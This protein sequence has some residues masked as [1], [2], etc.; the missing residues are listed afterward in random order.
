MSDP[1]TPN[2]PSSESPV[3]ESEPAATPVVEAPTPAPSAPEAAVPES[4]PLPP[5]PEAASVPD[6]AV[7]D[8]AVPE[9]AVPD[10]AVPDHAVVETAVVETAVVETAVLE[11]AV[12]EA[13]SVEVMASER[14]AEPAAERAA[15]AEPAAEA[16]AQPEASGAPA[17]P[18]MPATDDG[19]ALAYQPGDIVP[20]TVS[21]VRDDGVDIDLDA[22][23]RAIAPK[24]EWVGGATYAVGD[25][26]EGQVLRRQGA[27]KYVVS[28]K[29]A[30]KTR[31]WTRILAAK[32]SGEVMTGTVTEVVK[33]GLIVDLGLRAFL[34]E[35]LID[36]RRVGKPGELVGQSV[37][38][39]V[40]E[41]EKATDRPGERIVVSRKPLREKE[42]AEA[43]SQL[44][45]TIQPGERRRGRVSAIVPF[46]AFVDL[47]GIDGLIHVSEIAHSQV[48]SADKVLSVGEEVDVVVLEVNPEKR[49]IA[50]SRKR[51]LPDPW[52]AFQGQHQVGDLVFGTISGLAAFGAFVAIEGAELEGLIHISELSR[53]R[54]EQASDVVSVGEGVWVQ[55]LEINPEKR[56]LALSLRRALE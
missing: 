16:S 1:N 53:F 43:R 42:R 15:E 29:R 28:M 49:K 47:G 13:A 38:V 35:S 30:A 7:S 37:N 8:D 20:G 36:V 39:L 10:A 12:V 27:N 2:L 48:A 23:R 22:G 9:A 18:E 40:I 32:E 41:A 17:E 25:S 54:V 31:A 5:D 34:P 52:A 21:A 19:G 45:H 55:V 4:V 11:T 50:L 33:G 46:G 6:A 56:R 44:I 14:A 24:A 3:T 26:V 51:A